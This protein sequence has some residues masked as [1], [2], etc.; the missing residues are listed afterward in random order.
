MFFPEQRFSVILLSNNMQFPLLGMAFKIARIYLEPVLTP[1]RRV[2]VSIAD[3]RPLL[4]RHFPDGGGFY[5]VTLES[6]G[7]L[8][9]KTSSR[10]KYYL[11]PESSREFFIEGF[12]DYDVFRYSFKNIDKVELLPETKFL[13]QQQRIQ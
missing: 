2:S 12:E 3:I 8:A 13:K 1:L 7:R 10:E 6:D 9:L 4:K 11:V 5:D